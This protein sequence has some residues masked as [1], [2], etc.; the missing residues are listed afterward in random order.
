ML[1][2]DDGDAAAAQFENDV[3]EFASLGVATPGQLKTQKY[4]PPKARAKGVMVKDVA[5]LVAA[6]K[7]KGLV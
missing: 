4:D 3:D 6:L 1:D 2:P 7:N 5:E